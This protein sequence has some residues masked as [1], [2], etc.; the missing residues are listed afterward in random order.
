MNWS[1]STLSLPIAPFTE[2]L[3]ELYERTV[4]WFVR[5]IATEFPW[6]VPQWDEGL[7]SLVLIWSIVCWRAH[8]ILDPEEGFNFPFLDLLIATA[9]TT[10]FF[11][12]YVRYFAALF[13]ILFTLFPLIYA[14]LRVVTGAAVRLDNEIRIGYYMFGVIVA[15][16]LGLAVNQWYG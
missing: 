16:A 3:L 1:I 9:F 5:M 11:I 8:A 13:V 4:V 12:P 6:A 15:T 2:P 14:V 7:F 10:L